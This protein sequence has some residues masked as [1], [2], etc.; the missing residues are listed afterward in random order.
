MFINKNHICILLIII[1][2]ILFLFSIKFNYNESFECNPGSDGPL[3][4]YLSLISQDKDFIKGC[5]DEVIT[6]PCQANDPSGSGVQLGKSW[7]VQYIDGQRNNV[8]L[9]DIYTD[10]NAY[11]PCNSPNP[12]P[13]DLT[14]CGIPDPNSDCIKE[15]ESVPNY[16]NTDDRQQYVYSCK[17]GICPCMWKYGKDYKMDCLPPSNKKWDCTDELTCKT[18]LNGRY[19]TYDDCNKDRMNGK[20]IPQ[21]NKKWDCTDELNCDIVPNGRY[22]THYACN[23]DRMNGKCIPPSNK[24]WDCTD[25]LTCKTVLNGRYDTYDDCNKDRMNGKCIP[26][27]NKKWDCTD[28]LT[29]KTVLNGR[30][31]TYDDCNKDRMNGKCIPLII[32]GCKGTKFG[33][34]SDNITSKK[35]KEDICNDSNYIYNGLLWTGCTD[36]QEDNITDS[37]NI[38]NFNSICNNV[39]K[40]SYFVQTDSRGC[41]QP[42]NTNIGCSIVS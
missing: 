41:R 22:D 40:G 25:E 7:K 3:K 20:C 1:L 9:P 19:D 24:K 17:N 39:Q 4:T 30:Y 18:V 26:P 42:K 35:S 29:C 38:K 32:G 8:C 21:S 6:L 10:K 11:I 37:M 27:S 31:D 23:N 13:P 5:P 2:F 15:M 16:I 36:Y 34:C 28:E 12:G 14:G 33:C